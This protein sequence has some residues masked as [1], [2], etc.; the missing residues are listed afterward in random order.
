MPFTFGF[1][2]FLITITAIVSYFF[3]GGYFVSYYRE[4][5][6]VYL[7]IIQSFFRGSIDNIDNDSTFDMYTNIPP[8]NSTK[9]FN[10]LLQDSTGSYNSIINDMSTFGYLIV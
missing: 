8:P 3:T 10:Q 7:K 6:F 2:I 1:L 9:T 5:S 4:F